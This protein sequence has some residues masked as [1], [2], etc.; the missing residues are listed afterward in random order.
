MAVA[1]GGLA[2]ASSRSFGPLFAALTVLAVAVLAGRAGLRRM[3]APPRWPAV[4]TL[5]IV[6]LASVLS[7]IWEF[8][9]QPHPG[10]RAERCRAGHP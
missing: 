3:V 6:A 2:L 4:A 10:L 9:R 8:T 1:L 5:A 7:W